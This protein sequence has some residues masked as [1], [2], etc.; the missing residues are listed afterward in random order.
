M[1]TPSGTITAENRKKA[2]MTWEWEVFFLFAIITA[3]LFGFQANNSDT[4]SFLN[5]IMV[6]S[7][8]TAIVAPILIVLRRLK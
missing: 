8:L 6:L 5:A 2:V 7:G 4:R 3:V 1:N